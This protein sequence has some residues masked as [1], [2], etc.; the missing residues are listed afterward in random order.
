MTSRC[1]SRKVLMDISEDL[2]TCI[3]LPNNM[4]CK[5]EIAYLPHVDVRCHQH[6]CHTFLLNDSHHCKA[7]S[8]VRKP[9]E[10]NVQLGL[11]DVLC[12]VT[13][14]LAALSAAFLAALSTASSSNRACCRSLY[15]ACAWWYRA[16]VPSSQWS[17]SLS[18]S[19]CFLFHS[20][21]SV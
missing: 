4:R 18:C 19:A 3:I 6:R 17:L 14:S 8:P 15:A 2:S 10:I 5:N 11:F 12:S 13:L 9:R 7:A 1:P 16:N 20:L 21:A